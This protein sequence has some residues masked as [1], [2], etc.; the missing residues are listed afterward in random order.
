MVNLNSTKTD[1]IQWVNLPAKDKM[2]PPRYQDYQADQI[3]IRETPFGKIK[4]R[5]IIF[6][7]HLIT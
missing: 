5:L 7:S 4:V 3:P 1:E 2:I 6:P